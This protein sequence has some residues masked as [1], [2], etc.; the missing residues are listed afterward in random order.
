LWFVLYLAARALLEQED[1]SRA[2]RVG[3]AIL[4]VPAFI[5]FIREYVAAIR[6][7]DELERR[8]QLEALGLA[9]PLTLVLIMTLGLVQLAMPLNL[10]DWSYRHIWPFLYV[11]YFIGLSMARKRYA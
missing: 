5:W 1:L 6:T 10:D 2:L 3:M 7:M 4:P 11:F 9:F 8:I